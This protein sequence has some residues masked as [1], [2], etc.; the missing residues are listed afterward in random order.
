MEYANT[1]STGTTGITNATG[2]ARTTDTT[3]CRT[4]KATTNGPQRRRVSPIGT[5][6]SLQ[7]ATARTN[8]SDVTVTGGDTLAGELSP[9]ATGAAT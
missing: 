9:F 8:V 4:A 1:R 6:T 3:R 7:V 2:P 5:A